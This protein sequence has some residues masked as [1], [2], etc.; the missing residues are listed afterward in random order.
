MIRSGIFSLA[1]AALAISAPLSFWVVSP[2]AASAQGQAA[3]NLL[4]QVFVNEVA[5][6]A[7]TPTVTGTF[8]VFNEETVVQGG[9]RYKIQLLGPAPTPEAGQLVAVAV[10]VSWGRY[11]PVLHSIHAKAL[12]QAK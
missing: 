12:K 9:L 7:T 2:E 3:G 11:P 10:V 1:T 6:T 8:T 5:V 4:P